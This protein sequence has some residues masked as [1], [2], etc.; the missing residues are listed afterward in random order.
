MNAKNM[1][2]RTAVWWSL[3]VL[4]ISKKWF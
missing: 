2:S 1:K 3:P 4:F